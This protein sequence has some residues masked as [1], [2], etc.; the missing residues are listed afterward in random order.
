MVIIPYDSMGIA[1]MF[2]VSKQK[3]NN[4]DSK[5]EMSVKWRLILPIPIIVVVAIAT[6]WFFVPRMMADNAV[7]EAVRNG[8]QVVA[9]FKTI[10]GYYTRNVIAKVIA[11]GGVRP[12]V[13]H[14]EESDGIPLPATFVHDVSALLAGNDMQINL[15]SGFPFPVRGDRELDP[16]QQQAWEFLSAN[17]DET[18]VHREE[19]NG[20]ETVRVAIAD[21]MSAEACV[22]CHNA[23]PESPKTDWNLGDVRGVLEVSTVI[24]GALAS[25]A[26]LS[27]SLMMATVII[28]IILSLTTVAVARG[29]TGPLNGMVGAMKRLAD[30]ELDA[31]IPTPKRNDE[32]GAM[33]A[34]IH[35]FKDQATERAALEQQ[36]Q[37]EQNGK[38]AHMR[39]I[40]S[41]TEQFEADVENGLEAISSMSARMSESA[42]TVVDAADAASQQTSQITQRAEQASANS[43]A[44]ATAAEQLSTSIEEISRQV[45]KC[46]EVAAIGTTRA[47]NTD[48]QVHGLTDAASKI[49]EVVELI[50]D[51]AEQTNLLALNAT[52]EAARAGESGKGFAVVASEVK[53]LAGQTAKATDDIASQVNAIQIAAGRSVEALAEIGQTISDLDE[54]SS[55]IASA[56]EEQGAATQDIAH[57]VSATAEAI[58]QVN[59][60][61][62][63]V[64]S[65]TART[66]NASKSALQDAAALSRELDALRG[67]VTSFLADIRAA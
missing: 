47:S 15:Y 1:K 62:G 59:A 11:N 33:A 54:I 16:F 4:S 18:F 23:H 51:I 61:S 3:S 37:D 58:A 32:I 24:D 43:Q 56:I 41:V 20:H 45:T 52:I 36:A 14:A 50:N 48:S 40:T 38:D 34:A 42:G 9:Q 30:G 2:N 28:G 12:S 25:G 67:Q 17:P 22:N 63:T 57:N 39:R 65:A 44:V 13:N 35:V 19:L 66:E 60:D 29:V 31:E 7:S 10:R 5:S 21:R 8:E 27:N 6:V 26:T 49:G 53:S 55:S 46:S 64:S